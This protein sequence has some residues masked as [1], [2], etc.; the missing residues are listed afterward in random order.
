MSLTTTRGRV[1]GAARSVSTFAG[2]GVSHI[3]CRTADLFAAA[4]RHEWAALARQAT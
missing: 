3:A 4:I 1:A 2:A